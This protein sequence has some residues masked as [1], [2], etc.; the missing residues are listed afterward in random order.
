LPDFD[1]EL[2]DDDD[3]V[4][5]VLPEPGAPPPP[6]E[7]PVTPAQTHTVRRRPRFGEAVL[8]LGPRARGAPKAPRPDK[9][10]AQ[11]E[12]AQKAKALIEGGVN[13]GEQLGYGPASSGSVEP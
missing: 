5:D 8:G 6:L 9:L 11:R 12:H 7:P 2:L 3:V 10:L 13:K 1:D 4:L